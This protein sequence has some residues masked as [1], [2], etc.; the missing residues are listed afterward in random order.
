MF[1]FDTYFSLE[2]NATQG[3]WVICQERRRQKFRLGRFDSLEEARKTLE[4]PAKLEDLLD[5]EE[6]RSREERDRILG[7]QD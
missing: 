5:A 7:T 6:R 3:Y 4:D 2:Y 1:D